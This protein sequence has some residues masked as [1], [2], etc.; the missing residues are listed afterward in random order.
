MPKITK[1]CLK[2]STEYNSYY[3]QHQKYCS[4]TCAREG[5]IGRSWTTEQR[6]K[7]SIIMR[8]NTNNKDK[9][10]KL[11]VVS[12]FKKMYAEQKRAGV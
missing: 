3:N 12:I 10:P 2:C 6:K 5:Q 1:E 7:M 4:P 11:S 8:G 9:T